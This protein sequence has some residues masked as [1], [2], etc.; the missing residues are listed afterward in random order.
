M[1]RLLLLPLLFVALNSFAGWE[2]M[3][4][5]SVDD[6]GNCTGKAETFSLAGRLNVLL[7]NPDGLR[8]TK[9]YFEVYKVD[10]NTFME[11]LVITEEV[12]TTSEANK[13]AAVL[14]PTAKGN[15]LVKARN[16]YKDYITSR[17]LVIN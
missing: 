3:F 6:K 16:A 14:K 15:Y 7:L 5:D 4:C 2:M 9:V 8:T 17:E 10:P 1:K 11:D 12:N 13:V